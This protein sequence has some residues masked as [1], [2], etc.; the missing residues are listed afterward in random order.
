MLNNKQIAG[1]FDLLAK[2]ME[3][4]DDNP[5][6]IKTYANAYL[7]LRKLEGNLAE[8]SKAELASIKGVGSTV[9]DKIK[10]LVETGEMK[11]LE[12]FRE[13]TPE[14]IQQMLSIKGLGPKKVKQIWKEMEIE[15][16]GELLYACNENRLVA[17][18]GFGPKIQADI[19]EKLE[20][21]QASQGKF[22]YAHVHKQA[23]KCL[24]LIKTKQTST[25]IEI[26]GDVRRM[27]PEVKGIELLSDAALV[28][29]FPEIESME[30]I[31]D[32]WYFMAIPI[33]IYVTESARFDQELFRLNSSESF[34]A[35]FSN[36]E[37]SAGDDQLIFKNKG[38]PFIP[39][40][41]REHTDALSKNES[42][43][44]NL[45]EVEDIQGIVH[46]HSTYSDGL[47]TLK[48][49]ADYVRDSGFKYFVISDHSKSAGYASGLNEESVLMQWNEIENLNNQ[50]ADGFKI[51]KGIE[52]DIL[53]D[54][55]LDYSDDILAG[56]DI[57][58]ASV[59][60]GLNM[61]EEKAT[62]RLITAIE[63][64][65]TRILGHPTGRLLLA[66]RGYPVDYKKVID[67]CAT[68]NVVIELNANPQ[69]L[70]LDWTWIPYA[71]DKHVKV[72]INPD[73]HSKESIHYIKYGV[74]AA[75][76]GGLTK[77]M[78]LNTMNKEAFDQ[79]LSRK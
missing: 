60:S 65:Y 29:I 45:I 4:H 56:F 42:Y 37:L 74:A 69:R 67:A 25:K 48:E 3:L 30:Y 52:S 12:K 73:A 16:I 61:D 72:A 64:P 47:H 62:R 28:D 7:S 39:A 11:A 40:E 50:F 46:N 6:K 2:L 75:R 10:E 71:L 54:G 24:E 44:Q 23:E 36:E 49:M 59:H 53:T 76:K 58:I 31:D 68:N 51:Y 17:Y 27:M 57:V 15:T 66:R 34:Y 33:F 1:K 77:D 20:Y 26:C 78:C 9:A 41:F 63:N 55:S 22:L 21:F 79:W 38:L 35:A 70:D 5:F 14:G 32:Q 18:S 43:I 8:M 13:M 19:I